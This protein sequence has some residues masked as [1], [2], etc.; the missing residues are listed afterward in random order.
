MRSQQDAVFSIVAWTGPQQTAAPALALI[1]P[2]P[3]NN[4]DWPAEI[5]KRFWGTELW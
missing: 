3:D 4:L 5:G 1:N 2:S